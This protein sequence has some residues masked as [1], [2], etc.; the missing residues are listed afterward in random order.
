MTETKKETMKRILDRH[1]LT[2]AEWIEDGDESVNLFLDQKEIRGRLTISS[3]AILD[4]FLSLLNTVNKIGAG[5]GC[6]Y[7]LFSDLIKPLTKRKK[8][9]RLSGEEF[10]ALILIGCYLQ[11]LTKKETKPCL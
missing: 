7:T 6:D 2:D 5:H 10:N 1:G 3:P 11:N 9:L 8:G 4:I